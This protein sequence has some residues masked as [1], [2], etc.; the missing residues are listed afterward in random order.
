MV[1]A[2]LACLQA[3][4]QGW[5]AGASVGMAKQHDYEVGGPIDHRGRADT[6][7]FLSSIRS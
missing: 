6:D 2:D 1:A 5:L 3:S 4:A 7:P